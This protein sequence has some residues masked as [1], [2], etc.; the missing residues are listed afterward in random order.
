[1]IVPGYALWLLVSAATAASVAGLVWRRRPAPGATALTLLLLA[2][3]EWSFTYALHW[4]T[5][6]PAARL[7]WLD[8]TYLGAV[9]APTALFVFS[10]D[11]TQRGD[12]LT[13]GRLGLL[14][15]EPLITF[16]LLWTDPWHGLFFGGQRSANASTILS[17]GPWFWINVIYSYS[18]VLVGI[19]LLAQAF[20]RSPRQYRGQTGTL[21]LGALLP[22]AS[23]VLSLLGGNPFP[24]LDLTPLAFTATGLIFAW[25]LVGFQLLDIVPV[26][27]HAL[28]EQMRDGVL[29]LDARNRIVD[30]NPAARAHL[31]LAAAPLGQ[32]AE[33][34]LAHWPAVA[35]QLHAAPEVHAEL[36]LEE[37]GRFWDIR[38]TP[39]RDRKGRLTGR[40]VV[41]RDTT[42][43]RR[44]NQA[45]SAHLNEIASLH[46]QLREQAIRDP[47]TGLFNRRYLTETF[48]RELTRAAREQQPV[49]VV[50]LD[51]DHF[52]DL[53]D[54]FGHAV[55]DRV[56]QH[57]ARLLQTH[58]RQGDIACRWGGEEFVV[59]MP[60]AR[61]EVAAQRADQ[62]RRAILA[63]S[64]LAHSRPVQVTVSAGV[65]A[66]P[67]HGHTSDALLEAADRALY[68]AKAAGRN[69]VRLPDIP[70]LFD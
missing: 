37:D 65:A 62:W 66:A 55:G 60:G 45:L 30:L 13:P 17:G 19:A 29:V 18:L 61:V 70:A 11:Y 7:F 67:E 53:N 9:C 54:T 1:M 35:A 27:R 48:D 44:A 57:L 12:N 59:V 46:D 69:Q 36:T 24:N 3:V 26:A 42:D 43:L 39:L 38:L 33:T 16:L 50:I 10:L 22:W 15:V 31:R 25:G 2:L 21:L 51:I 23:N 52:K 34:Q 14:A 63:E 28:V 20:W 49:S 41:W 8:A 58:T 68:A 5:A 64:I 6:A 47:L 40:L 32:P 4:L 56:L